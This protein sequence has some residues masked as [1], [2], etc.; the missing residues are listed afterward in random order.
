MSNK[1]EKILF[2]INDKINDEALSPFSTFT[3]WKKYD[4]YKLIYYDDLPV[5][6]P[7]DKS[8]GHTY[9]PF[10]FYP[11]ILLDFI[12]LANNVNQIIW[13]YEHDKS[14]DENLLLKLIANRTIMFNN[15]YG[16]F[17]YEYGLYNSLV[18]NADIAMK[19]YAKRT[20][21]EMNDGDN[22]NKLKSEF[23]SYSSLFHYQNKY[24]DEKHSPFDNMNWDVHITWD[25]L[26]SALFMTGDIN[27][28]VDI[29][30]GFPQFSW[31]Y[32]SLFK[33]LKIMAIQSLVID[34]NIIRLCALDTC[35]KPFI[36]TRKDKKYC[37][38]NCSGT[39][40]QREFQKNKRLKGGK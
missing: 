35:R 31:V 24:F 19:S 30:S 12:D 17:N 27:M 15:Q 1:N 5:I 22:V 6:I 29:S 18:K 2:K 13:D 21:I 33:A 40:R 26:F 37:N 16:L 36:L 4:G 11:D 7:I 25:K 3:K 39:A 20:S 34:K 14:K 9:N 28:T 23:Q 38:D 8:S 32:D 10:D